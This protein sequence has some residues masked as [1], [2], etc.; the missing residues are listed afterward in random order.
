MLEASPNNTEFDTENSLF[1]MEN[2]VEDLY[3]EIRLFCEEA[4][5]P[6]FNKLDAGKLIRFL[7]LQFA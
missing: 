2:I 3:W 6:L 1:I 7:K 4:C 5:S